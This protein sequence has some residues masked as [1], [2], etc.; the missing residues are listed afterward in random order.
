[1]P[2]HL[3][4]HKSYHVYNAA[5][6][7]RVRRD[8]A[9]AAANAKA[10]ADLAATEAS[11]DRFEILRAR[12]VGQPDPLPS[13]SSR[14]LATGGNHVDN[15]PLDEDDRPRKK[16]RTEAQRKL[17][18]YIDRTGLTDKSGHIN[19]FPPPPARV[20][21]NTEAEKE[22]KEKEAEW[23]ARNFQNA[24][25]RPCDELRPWYTTGGK[26]LPE[27]SFRKHGGGKWGEKKEER[28]KDWAD[29]LNL[30]NTGVRKLRE[31]EDAHE[32]WRRGRE[33]E[34][35]QG[36]DGDLDGDAEEVLGPQPRGDSRSRGR[37]RVG[38][39]ERDTGDTKRGSHDH[40]N[41]EHRRRSSTSSRDH[42]SRKS[43]SR[44]R[45][46]RPHHHHHHRHHHH[47]NR[48]HSDTP[49]ERLAKLR[50]EREKREAAERAKAQELLRREKERD[51]PG[52]EP[53]QGGRYSKQFGEN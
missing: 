49:D 40:R 4:H 25:G 31:A 19:L 44:S 16:V 39:R 27:S 41:Q 2:L 18:H 23:E 34:V 33:R 50:A 9:E 42:R 3:L 6:V 29:P 51:M 14:K 36:G 10:A 45:S 37:D 21:K 5:N 11:K 53:V 35:G 8:E 30:V 17:D 22:R 26:A 15:E 24:L 52:W 7:Q 28:R 20:Q 43:R 48:H 12:A 38:K 1:M 32:E 47:S 13:P 46:R